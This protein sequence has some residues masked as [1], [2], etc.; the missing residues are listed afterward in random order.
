MAPDPGRPYVVSCA[1]HRVVV[2]EADA[3]AL[4]DAVGRTHRCTL[5]ATELLNL[6]VRD[7]IENHCGTGLDR[8]F[9]Q[10]WLLNAYYAVSTGRKAASVDPAVQNVYDTYMASTVDV[11]DRRG[12]SR[13]LKYECINLAAVA[14]TNVWM[15]FQERVL[16]HTRTRFALQGDAYG[17]LTKDERCA[18]KLALMQAA[19][20]VCR[21]PDEPHR[22]PAEFHAWI[23]A[24]RARLGIDSAV[25]EWE[26]KPLLY[27]L[28]AKPHRFLVAM[29]AMSTDRHAAG[30]AA[31]SLFPLRRSNVPCHARFDK[32]ALSGL[33]GIRASSST[34]IDGSGRKRRRDDPSLVEEK[35][36]FFS[37]LLELR[38]IKRRHHFDFS[39]TT[40]GVSLHLNMRKPRREGKAA[41]VAGMPT[42]GVHSI[43]E[44]KQAARLEDVHAIGIDPGRVE[45]LVAV[46][47]ETGKRARY[48]LKQRRKELRTRQR[49]DELRRSKPQ[50][51]AYA[52]ELMSQRNSK[53]PG[54]TEFA[55]FA[56]RRR[57]L[58]RECPELPR[59]YSE[60]VHRNNRRKTRIKAQQSETKL[61][62][63]LHTLHR[64]SRTPVLAYGAWGL[65]A[66]RAG[67]ACNKG[68]PPAI[69]V[70][71]M[72][73][74][75]LHF[76]VVPTPEHYTSKT[77]VRCLGPCGPH[78]TLKTKGGTEIRGLRVCQHEGCGLLQNRDR[79]GASN[80]GLQFERLFRGDP[81]LRPMS[82]E[83]V[84][85]NRL[86]AC[87]ECS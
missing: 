75:A 73:R 66:G 10:H 57:A 70:G 53:A 80:I 64:D 29:H 12:L 14:A 76:V 42:R 48:T 34:K 62:E 1:L 39:F 69:G 52:E 81:P 31:F 27:H 38:S 8:L 21:A 32:E 55:A 24:E 33:F 77:C 43:D 3:A 2:G 51:V 67:A 44:L 36:S 63:R 86:S 5:H 23:D 49:E 40:D 11:P 79:T 72:K 28:K 56:S 19:T 17:S 20:D 13:T 60:D 50:T 25:G 45:L 61:I 78:P 16:K 83:E 6:Y 26:G 35:V 84:E 58:R 30:R 87:V 18:R 7:R 4:K 15:H 68:N 82:D 65:Q 74:L 54:L 47:R 46:D 85:F 22:S 71:L 41:R 59:F 9:D 37:Q